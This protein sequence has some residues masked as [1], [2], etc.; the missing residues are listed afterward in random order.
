MLF[1][2]KRLLECKWDFVKLF[3]WKELWCIFWFYKC[4]IGL[5]G[6]I[7]LLNCVSVFGLFDLNIFLM[8]LMFILVGF[9]R[10]VVIGVLFNCIGLMLVLNFCMFW[11]DLVGEFFDCCLILFYLLLLFVLG[12]FMDDWKGE[13]FIG[14]CE[15]G[16]VKFLLFLFLFFVFGF[17]KEVWNGVIIGCFFILVVVFLRNVVWFMIWVEEFFLMLFVVSLMYIFFW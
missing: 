6:V 9:F 2:F 5:F 15:V 12:L 13:K 11:R 7:K 3:F 10:F 17:I 4:F 8:F 1:V 16:V 14:D